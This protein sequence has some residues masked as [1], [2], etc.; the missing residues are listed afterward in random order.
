MR[1]YWLMMSVIFSI[2]CS[3]G[4]YSHKDV[5]QNNKDQKSDTVGFYQARDLKG[6]GNFKIHGSTYKETFK[7]LTKEFKIDGRYSL[8]VFNLK[9]IHH[10]TI[11]SFLAEDLLKE[12][13][14]GCP[15]VSGINVYKYFIG[16]IE[17]SDLK[18]TFYQ[19]TLISIECAQND[20]IDEGFKLKYGKGKSFNND[21]WKTP[22]G[23][24]HE[25]PSDDIMNKCQLL[26]IDQKQIWENKSVIATS[27][28]YCVYLYDGDK[29]LGGDMNS[30]FHYFSIVSKNLRIKNQMNN[31]DSIAQKYKEKIIEVNN[32]KN[33]EK[34]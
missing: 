21:L 32:R 7:T 10:D 9:E 24:T 27:S 2:L 34:L 17:I 13:I 6:L 3:C 20:K 16:D 28:F 11:K 33:L 19:D 26:K 31:C 5:S 29:Y 1:T 15:R 22:S 18:L 30:S 4:D 25:R 12:H 23:E 14:F 8:E